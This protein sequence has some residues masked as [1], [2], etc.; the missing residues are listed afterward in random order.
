[1]PPCSRILLNPAG[2]RCA[3]TWDKHFGSA[4]ALSWESPAGI[5]ESSNFWW[6]PARCP[7]RRGRHFLMFSWWFPCV[8]VISWW[9]AGLLQISWWSPGGLLVSARELLPVAWWS[10]GVLVL[11]AELVV[12]GLLSLDGVLDKHRWQVVAIFFYRA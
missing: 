8:V 7:R 2:A 5:L 12:G 9:S 4:L 3:S 6:F 10:P 1:M 11:V